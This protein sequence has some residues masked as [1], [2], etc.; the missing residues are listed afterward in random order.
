MLDPKPIA[1]SSVLWLL[2]EFLKNEVSAE[3]PQEDFCQRKH[4]VVAY[5]MSRLDNTVI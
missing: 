3:V 5:T 4:W 1:T 2:A